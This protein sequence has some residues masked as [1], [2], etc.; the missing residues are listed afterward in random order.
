MAKLR[1]RSRQTVCASTRISR[2]Y[3]KSRSPLERD[4]IPRLSGARPRRTTFPRSPRMISISPK[5]APP[6]E[7]SSQFLLPELHRDFL[8]AY[9]RTTE[10]Q[11]PIQSAR[12]LVILAH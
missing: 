10:P 5:L 11:F 1:S 7:R 12:D 4:R 6:P 3:S 2:R 9:I 8:R